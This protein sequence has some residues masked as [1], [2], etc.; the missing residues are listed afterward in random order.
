MKAGAGTRNAGSHPLPYR[1]LPRS[2]S[3]DTPV[4]AVPV[5]SIDAKM[6][7]SEGAG[8]EEAE[9][10]VAEMNPGQTNRPIDYATP[11]TRTSFWQRPWT[12]RK[13]IITAV[14]VIVG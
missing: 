1:P 5:V 7:E 12:L 9:A 3:R 8:E 6:R 13:K 4:P 14:V 2:P 11:P 10:R